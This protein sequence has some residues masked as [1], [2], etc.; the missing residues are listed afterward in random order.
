MDQKKLSVVVLTF[1]S[2]SIIIDCLNSI[3]LN[4]DLGDFLE[5]VVVDN[6][7]S[8]VDFMFDL[9]K[10]SFSFEIILIKNNINL[11]YGAGNNV[12][13]NI[14]NSPIIMIVNP[15][16][17]FIDLKLS[18]VIRYFDN[19]NLSMLGFRQFISKEKQG[20]SFSVNL[21]NLSIF[22]VFFTLFSNRIGYYDQKRMYLSGS[23]FAIK[24][25]VFIGVGLFDEN[26]FLYGEENDL[27][28]RVKSNFPDYKIYFDKSLT[29]LH[30]T[31][32]R[33]VSEN[34]LKLM[35][36]SNL[37]FCAKNNLDQK[38]Y[39]KKLIH[40]IKFYRLVEFL[41]FRRD[42]FNSYNFYLNFLKSEIKKL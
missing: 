30:L 42:N 33:P 13:I 26:I 21:V 32:N 36:N 14:S 25:D 40:L 31:E 6:N 2:E 38:K 19:N 15:D 34:S 29:Y 22:G 5:I 7:S 24:K 9:I 23:C 3:L 4:N 1:N 20:M 35:F 27:H 41:R 16:V 11:G 17:R 8:K 37:Y 18:K 39:V 28:Y 10:K 12:G